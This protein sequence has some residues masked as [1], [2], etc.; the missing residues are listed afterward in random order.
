MT[1]D[2]GKT[3]AHGYTYWT[4]RVDGHFY[5][6]NGQKK[7]FTTKKAAQ[8]YAENRIHTGTEFEINNLHFRVWS[9]IALRST[10]ALCLE[11][12]DT[13]FISSSEY[14][15][16]DTTV[17]KAIINTFDISTEPKATTK[18]VLTDDQKAKKAARAKARREAKKVI[19]SQAKELGLNVEGLTQDK[20]VELINYTRQLKAQQL[21]AQA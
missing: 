6:E 9:D 18:K 7:L 15:H 1:I 5:K 20:A 10:L 3:Q 2:Y 12:G 17:R 14:I 11:T 13:K 19:V 4:I 8:F 21:M 16:K